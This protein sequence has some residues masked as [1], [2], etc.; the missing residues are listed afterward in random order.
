MAYVCDIWVR[1][2]APMMPHICEELWSKMGHKDY[3]S[4]ATWPRPDKKLIDKGV[5]MA[6]QVVDSTIRDI[7]EITR[8]LKGKKAKTVHVYVAP[9]W[10]FRAM[11]SIRDANIPTIVGDIMKHLMANEEYRRHGKEVKIIVDRITRE[12]GLWD[13]SG[14]AKDEMAVLLDSADYIGEELKVDVIVQ[15]SG[16]PTYDPQKKARFALPGRVSLYLE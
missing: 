5:E 7:R 11:K 12:N 13:H 16:H 8:L 6:Q 4:L 10:M 15:D 1:L 2:A 9:E 3:V 14:S